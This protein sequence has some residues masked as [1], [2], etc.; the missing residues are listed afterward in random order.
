[1][2]GKKAK[3]RSPSCP[4]PNRIKQARL[5]IIRIFYLFEEV[6]HMVGLPEIVLYVIIF[7][8]DSEF[9]KLV[10]ECSRLLEETMNFAL[11][12]HVFLFC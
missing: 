6:N 3:I 4:P 5:S 11:Y 9:Y 1:M 2:Q 8:R 7:S 10:F 12:L